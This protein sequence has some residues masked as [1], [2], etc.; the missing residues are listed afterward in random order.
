MGPLAIHPSTGEVFFAHRS[1]VYRVDPDSG[2]VAS[3]ATGGTRLT[4]LQFSPDGE[5]LF[6]SDAENRSVVKIEAPR[7]EGRLLVT[8]WS[9]SGT[10][11]TQVLEGHVSDAVETPALFYGGDLS[12]L[13]DQV[14]YC[15]ASGW[16]PTMIW[17]LRQEIWRSD[18]DGENTLNLT[19][20]SGVTGINCLPRWSPD[21]G[22]V[23]FVHSDPV[24]G[25][26]PCE[27]GFDL[28]VMN[29]DGTGAYRLTQVYPSSLCWSATGD[30]LLCER[31]AVGSAGERQMISITTDGQD[32][33]VL[34][35]VGTDASYSPDGSKIISSWERVG[36]LNG[37]PGMWRQLRLTDADGSQPRTLV[38]QFVRD[39]DARRHL[40]ALGKDDSE[41][42][43][44]SLRLWVGPYLARW[45]PTGDRI[46]FASALP[47]RPSGVQY[48]LQT[49]LWMYEVD[50]GML[51]QIS[52][53]GLGEQS[54][55]WRGANTLPDRPQVTVGN[56]TVSFAEV[57]RPG[58]TTVVRRSE[59]S[60]V[61]RGY[62]LLGEYYDIR[63]TAEYR[64]PVTIRMAYGIGGI[65]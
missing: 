61:P 26:Q 58:V 52:D 63:T 35:D 41:D 48:K 51:T 40:A 2:S 12:P 42:E 50:T 14:L 8:R 6:V 27:A 38:E 32:L 11:S 49:E 46:I 57:T 47:F 54:L 53:D 10:H 36:R 24:E 19:A 56:T 62:R 7:I 31:P 43:I 29:A 17:K 44:G 1:S 3:Y 59:P 23:A 34:A 9:A 30:R 16:H 18:L 22:Q 21:V 33:K 55:S 37:E 60:D 45:S 15:K 39:T 5:A 65:R 20:V 64:G 25:R 13:G 28:W 4:G